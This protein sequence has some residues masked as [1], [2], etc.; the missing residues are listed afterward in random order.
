M[1]TEK[2]CNEEKKNN[3]P[4]RIF[5]I[6]VLVLI[7]SISGINISFGRWAMYDGLR[8]LPEHGMTGLKYYFET[9]VDYAIPDDSI[10]NLKFVDIYGAYQNFQQKRTDNGLG[11]YKDQDGFLLPHWE[12]PGQHDASLE[13]TKLLYDF[14]NERGSQFRY[15]QI[16]ANSIKSNY[17]ETV[18]SYIPTNQMIAAFVSDCEVNGIPCLDGNVFLENLPHSELFNKTDHH[19]A[20]PAV[21]LTYQE[22]IKDLSSGTDI[23]DE[24]KFEKLVWEKSFLGGLAVG[25]GQYYVG[26]D[27]YIL[28]KPDYDTLFT[29]RF[30]Q[31][32]DVIY[33]RKGDFMNALYDEE[34]LYDPGYLNKYNTALSFSDMTWLKAG[35]F[36][37]HIENHMAD[38]DQKVLLISDSYGQPFATY[39]ALSN[40]EV[41]YLSWDGYY[42]ENYRD[43][44]DE[45][46][47][48][49]VLVLKWAQST[50][51]NVPFE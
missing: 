41:A 31:G 25:M 22:L 15:I 32:E 20:S 9:G 3:Y 35:N 48:D 39:L 28:Y 29:M 51:I 44:I 16:P 33:E 34:R 6:V 37:I 23:I 21:F 26:K 50:Y 4:G 2:N 1:N 11:F 10:Y 14:V 7:C 43:F 36:Y 13:N 27:D 40:K 8:M 19:W 17:P 46:D 47:P 18:F 49:V 24:S 42:I 30:I 12:A 45:Y 5:I 38:N